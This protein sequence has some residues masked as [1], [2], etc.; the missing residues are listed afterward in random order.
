MTAATHPAT[1]AK[2]KPEAGPP[3]SGLDL[4]NIGDLSDLLNQ[5]ETVARS[6]RPLELSL[7][8]IDE[9]PHQP[10]TKDNPGFL[11]ESLEELARTIRLRGVKTPISVRDNPD[12]AG[13]YLINHGARRVRAS[14][15]AHKT[16]IPAFVDNDYN[17]A[18]QVIENLQRNELTPREIADFIGRELAKGKKKGDIAKELGKS[19]AFVSQHVTL[20]DL[21]DPIAEAFNS[22]RCR[23]VTV[24]NELVTAH[25]KARNEVG[26]WLADDTQ[27]ITR[28]SVKLLREYLDDKRQHEDDERNSDTLES[29]ASARPAAGEGDHATHSRRDPQEADPNRL[30]RAIVHVQHDGRPARLILNRRPPVEGHA[31]LK[32]EDDGHELAADL[33]QVQLVALLEG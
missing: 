18:D 14:R 19:P 7:E 4:E 9:D 5:P 1:T 26:L 6:F 25:K 8:L 32:Y 22:G 10:R 17:E 21:P 31:W 30:R 29:T 33:A 20:L 2:K 27:E 24:I 11:P 16:T 23:D 12:A 28:G 15:L 13:R 3:A